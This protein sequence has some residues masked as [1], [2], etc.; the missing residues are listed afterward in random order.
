ML[1]KYSI[2][3]LPLYFFQVLSMSTASILK[4]LKDTQSEFLD[5]RFTDL[6]GQWHHMTF[7]TSAVSEKMLTQGVCFDG[8]SLVGWRPVEDSDMILK[9]DLT[10]AIFIDPFCNQTTAVMFCDIY[11]PKNDKPYDRDPRSIAKN[12]QY[13]LKN[14]GFAD[15]AYFGPEPEFF[16][17]DDI[18]FYT[19]TYHSFFEMKSGEFD[20]EHSDNSHRPGLKGGYMPVAP[21]DFLTNLRSQMV[22]TMI[23]MGVAAE[24]HHHEVAAAQ[25]EIGFRFGQLVQAADHCLLFKYAVKN[26]AQANGKSATFMPKPIFGDNGSGMHVH[27]SLWKNDQPL[28]AGKNYAGLSETALYYIGGILKHAKALNAFTN[29]ST[30]SYKRLVPGY[31]A[32]TAL[33]YSARNR[34]AAIRVPI[35]NGAKEQRIEARFPDPVANPYLAFSAMLMAGLDGIKNKIHP[36]DPCEENLWNNSNIPSVSYSLRDALD[37]LKND[38][39]FLLQGD[40]FSKD[41]IDAYI[42]VKWEEVVELEQMPHPIEFKRSY[43]L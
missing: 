8:S 28:F 5:L 24:K 21:L 25:H 42:Q 12:A 13:Y 36:G 1:Y 26:V 35:S 34:S 3:K 17:F 22:E 2:L 11:D 4:F 6:H 40:V 27:Q 29:P 32:P 7:S 19:S 16:I 10:D 15:T 33:A 41:F 9:P 23:Q 38:H 37:N 39:D 18:Q 30:N 20:H 31:E 14:S 43:S